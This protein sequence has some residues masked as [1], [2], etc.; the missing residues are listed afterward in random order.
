MLF[1][2]SEATTPFVNLRVFLVKAG[3]KDSFIYLMNGVAMF[4]GFVIFRVSLV[5]VIPYV[6]YVY[7]EQLQQMA[8]F[9]TFMTTLGYLIISSLNVMWTYAIGMG[10]VKAAFAK[11]KSVQKKAH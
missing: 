10:L 6:F 3:K 1:A 5:F 9:P 2:L 8:I 11:K 4:L 7:R